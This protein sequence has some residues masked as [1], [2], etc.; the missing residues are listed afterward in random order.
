V[1]TTN[2]DKC[3]DTN[4]SLCKKQERELDRFRTYLLKK[5]LGDFNAKNERQGI[6][7]PTIGNEGSHE[8]N[9]DNKGR[10]LNFAT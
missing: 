2:D 6:F 4:C 5:L 8:S 9:K 10:L 1:H 3:S 7:K